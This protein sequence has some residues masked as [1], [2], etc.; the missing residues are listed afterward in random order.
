MKFT[1]AGGVCL[2]VEAG[3][4]GAVV[5]AVT[6]TGQ[7][8][9]PDRIGT[10]FEEFEQG[11]LHPARGTGTGLGLAIT[12]RIVDRMAGRIE[13]E[14]RPGEGSTFRVSLPLRP[15][16]GARPRPEREAAAGLAVL[17][18][19]GSPFE[20]ICLERRLAEAGAG[21][22]RA[23]DIRAGARLMQARRFDVLIVDGAAG[24]LD[25]RMAARL[26]RLAGIGRTIV[27]LSPFER[28][29]FGPPAAAGFDAYLTKPVRSRSLFERLRRTPEEARPIVAASLR[30]PEHQ[31]GAGQP[32]RVLLA[33]DNDVNAL[34]AMK[35]LETRGAL[36]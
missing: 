24:E 10:I 22:A 7:G 26:A 3:P 25:V 13:V 36:V 20:P 27:M 2:S 32:R 34:L 15:A 1:D 35:A 12:R 19:G 14:S 5:F 16:P 6:D 28:R 4:D 31:P 17:L 8:I 9:A 33:E 23:A 29:G 21:T 18:V 11:G 30:P